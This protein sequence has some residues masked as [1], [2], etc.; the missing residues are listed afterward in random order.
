MSRKISSSSS[1]V[2]Y[3]I[4]PY[5]LEDNKIIPNDVNTNPIL[6]L[7]FISY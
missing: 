2:G 3:F 5:E 7:E 6:P 1:S 4:I